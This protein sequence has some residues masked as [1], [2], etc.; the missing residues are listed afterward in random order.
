M[1]QN[2]NDPLTRRDVGMEFLDVTDKAEL[3]LDTRSRNNG[4]QDDTWIV[5]NTSNYFIDNHL[6]AIIKGL[7]A[8]VELANA[9]GKTQ[10]GEFPY[11]RVYL[12][13][14]VIKP[15]ATMKMQLKFIDKRKQD[16]SQPFSYEITLKSGHGKP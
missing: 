9:S 3:A 11:L 10:E 16:N 1:A 2:N 14:G 5:K 8:D 7:P 13:G 6:L 4:M 15:A 12:E